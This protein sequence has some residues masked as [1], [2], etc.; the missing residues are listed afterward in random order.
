MHVLPDDG[1]IVSG[2][3][4]QDGDL[5]IE[6]TNQEHSDEVRHGH[7][8]VEWGVDDIPPPHI[9]ILLGLQVRH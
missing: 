4:S 9:S 1:D 6:V 5:T 8:G 7:E 2:K 3:E